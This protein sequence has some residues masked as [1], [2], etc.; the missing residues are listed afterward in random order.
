MATNASTL[1]G[2]IRF[3]QT[4]A[5]LVFSIGTKVFQNIFVGRG[6]GEPLLPQIEI[7]QDPDVEFQGKDSVALK[8]EGILSTQVEK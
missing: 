7:L 1:A 6:P 5:G 8:L 2:D 4:P 3:D